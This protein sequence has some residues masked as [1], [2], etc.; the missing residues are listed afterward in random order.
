MLRWMGL[1]CGFVGF[2]ILSHIV[3]NTGYYMEASK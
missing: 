1:M 2:V 3:K